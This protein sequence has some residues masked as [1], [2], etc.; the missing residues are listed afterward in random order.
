MLKVRAKAGAKEPATDDRICIQRGQLI[1]INL[2]FTEASVVPI[3]SF[4]HLARKR[5]WAI[6]WNRKPKIINLHHVS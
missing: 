1:K 6:L 5:L 4:T 2:H 3:P